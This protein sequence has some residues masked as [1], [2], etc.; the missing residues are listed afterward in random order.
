MVRC[1]PSLFPSTI[2]TRGLAARRL[3]GIPPP[4]PKLQRHYLQTLMLSPRFEPRPY[5]TAV[6]VTDPIILDRRQENSN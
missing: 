5:G 1:L 2:L 3:F 6:S 4:L